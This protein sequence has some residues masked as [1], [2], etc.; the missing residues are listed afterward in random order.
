MFPLLVNLVGRT[1]LVVGA[2][3]V[4]GRRAQGLLSAGAHVRLVDPDPRS[5]ISA[6]PNLDRLVAPYQPSHL[7]DV[8]LVF[9]CATE[10][11]NAAVVADARAAGV[12]VGDAAEPDRGDVIV[13]GVVRRGDLC[14]TVSTGGASP[15]LARRIA[16]E[17][18]ERYDPTYADWVRVLGEVR[19][20]AKA[21]VA[22]AGARQRVLAE[23]TDPQ[24]LER[25]RVAGPDVARREMLSRL[26]A[27]STMLRSE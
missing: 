20:A 5:G 25:I 15:H 10:A 26:A 22:D 3:A 19:A 24:W 17:L 21:A 27:V 12:W 6:H 16:S 13:P 8:S 14:L 9:A 11:V 2:G 4:G 18:G 1:V 7:N 23:F